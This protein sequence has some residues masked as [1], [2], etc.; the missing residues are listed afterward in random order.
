VSGRIYGPGG[1]HWSGGVLVN[2]DGSDYVESS[3]VVAGRRMITVA[4][5]CTRVVEVFSGCSR[6]EE[7]SGLNSSMSGKREVYL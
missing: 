6:W 4:I 3:D 5:M 2:E 1:S 7:S